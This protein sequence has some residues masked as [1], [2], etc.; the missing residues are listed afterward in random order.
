MLVEAVKI[1]RRARKGEWG[2]GLE[3]NGPGIAA[4]SSL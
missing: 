1:G 2:S 4:E 3:G